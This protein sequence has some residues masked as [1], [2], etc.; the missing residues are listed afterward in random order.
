MIAIVSVAVRFVFL[1]FCLIVP[2]WAALR[3]LGFRWRHELDWLL[4]TLTLSVTLVGLTVTL[5]LLGH[6]YYRPLAL[7]LLALSAGYLGVD[8][9]RNRA[10]RDEDEDLADIRP[11]ID[12]ID[13]AVI[14]TCLA[15]LAVY[16]I[17]GLTS[18]ITWWDGLAS[19]GKWAAD[20]GRRTDSANYVVGG[21]LQLVPRF[22]SVLYKATGASRDILPPDFFAI[23]GFHVVLAMWFV[24]AS[25]R[26]AKLLGLPAWPVLVAG[27]GSMQ[28][29]EHI[30]SG[31]V[32]VLITT[33]AVTMMALYLGYVHS[34]W[35]VH[36]R[37]EW[38]VLGSALFACLFCKVTGWLVLL[39]VGGLYLLVRRD[40]SGAE[41]RA[42]VAR[43]TRLAALVAVLA[44]AP[45]LAEQGYSELRIASRHF[46]PYEVNISLR[47][48]PAWLAKDA[49]VTYR[50]GGLMS[51]PHLVQLRFWNSYNVPALLRWPHT[52]LLLLL[53]AAGAATPFGRVMLPII[54]GYGV[55]W[56]LWSSYDQ[57]NLFV[58]LPLAA[59]VASFGARR[60]WHARPAFFWRNALAIALGLFL[61]LSGGSILKEAQG[62]LRSLSEGD[63]ALSARLHAMAGDTREKIAV[64]YRDSVPEFEF[65]D[66]LSR[67]TGATHVLV[68]WPLFRFFPNGAHALSLWRY[69]QV[70][71]GDVF[72]GHEWHRPPRNAEWVLVQRTAKHRAWLFGQASEVGLAALDMPSEESRD[73]ATTAGSAAGTSWW[74]R[75]TPDDLRAGGY[76][77]WEAVVASGMGD[78]S[79]RA[80]YTMAATDRL[81]LAA[82]S[83]VADDDARTDGTKRVSGIVSLRADAALSKG[84][85]R[86]GADSLQPGARLVSF[87]LW[88]QSR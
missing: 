56:L 48:I 78:E 71:D 9:L 61:L 51:R 26:L 14:V 44:M 52:L 88:R 11:P 55:V 67:R 33:L 35:K 20:W 62:R 76:L 27:I 3:A 54:G 79:V 25:W 83:T 81:D 37:R 66:A 30:G 29:R 53:L 80:T 58:V 87:R 8:L 7:L 74:Y 64:F 6:I 43:V 36:A 75:V 10:T 19:W 34:A 4:A 63:R 13:R 39:I 23:H 77:A 82:T 24:A 15:F 16:L 70:R 50:G 72:S 60:L 69:D 18:P 5:L 12:N 2:G 84:E 45:F 46:D 86:I 41:R 59:I 38:V 1:L 42:S 40:M 21:Y 31:T 49:D 28:F 32:D 57:R 22:E 47:E 73:G 17:D 68:T 65:L 85:L